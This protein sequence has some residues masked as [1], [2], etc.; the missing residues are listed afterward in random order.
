MYRSQYY[1]QQEIR[2]LCGQNP[3]IRDCWKALNNHPY[4]PTIKHRI[5]DICSNA[6]FT[7]PITEAHFT[8]IANDGIK[9]IRVVIKDDEVKFSE[10]K[11]EARY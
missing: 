11:R 2:E 9:T 5:I 4:F 1:S 7:L 10:T 6:H 3:D 8:Y